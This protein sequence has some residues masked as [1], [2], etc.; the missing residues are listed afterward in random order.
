MDMNINGEL[1]KLLR[2]QRSWSQ[3]ELAAA[4]DLSLRTVQRIENANACSL[5]SKKA[6]ASVFEIEAKALEVDEEAVVKAIADSR[7]KLYGYTGVTIGLLCAYAAITYSLLNDSMTLGEAGVAYGL[8]GLFCG[9]CGSIIGT[10]ARRA[11]NN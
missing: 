11:G 9:F 10:L 6:L 2:T 5:E 7:G 1:V 8:T 3:E 4:A